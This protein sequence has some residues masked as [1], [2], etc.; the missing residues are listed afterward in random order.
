[1]R[2]PVTLAASILLLAL[3][4]TP[5]AQV[6]HRSSAEWQIRQLHAQLIQGYIHNDAGL[7]E[8]VLADEY[9]F[10]DDSGRFLSKAHI[11]ES[12][13]S[14]DHHIFS[15]DMSEEKI[16]IYGNAAVMTYRYVSKERYKGEDESG[17]DRI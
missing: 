7:L 3:S 14:G 16:R 9:T 1:M 11:V 6:D 10:I 2:K 12:F 17:D 8:R 15:Y 4:G 5:A 13:R